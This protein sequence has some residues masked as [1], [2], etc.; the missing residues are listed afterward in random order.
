MI[1][2][3][4]NLSPGIGS[5]NNDIVFFNQYI[6]RVLRID[7]ATRL[8]VAKPVLKLQMIIHF[9]RLSSWSQFPLRSSSNHLLQE[10]DVLMIDYLSSVSSSISLVFSLSALLMTC[11][12]A[13]CASSGL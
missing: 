12:T 9:A 7:T 1:R 10:Q 11:S 2:L 8:K 4:I 6:K 5:C 3:I 13:S